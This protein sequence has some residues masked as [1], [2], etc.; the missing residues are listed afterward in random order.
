[1]GLFRIAIV[2]A[3]GVALLPSDREHQQQ[4]YQRASS[5][6]S[7]AVTFCD[8]NAA[9][10]EQAAGLWGEFKKK[11]EF[12]IELALDMVRDGNAVNNDAAKSKDAIVSPAEGRLA[13]SSIVK[14]T[15]T[16]ADLKPEWRGK[17]AKR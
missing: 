5:A 10:C 2:A 13:T 3:V 1:M 16:S 12:G 4:L 15:L 9:T 8:R 17:V 7:W 11:A 6:T 14:T